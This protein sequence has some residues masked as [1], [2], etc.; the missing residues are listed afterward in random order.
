MYFE[1]SYAKRSEC[2][3]IFSFILIFQSFLAVLLVA[4]VYGWVYWNY[5]TDSKVVSLAVSADGNYTVAGT[6]NGSVYLFDRTG[7]LLWTHS[8]SKDVECVAISGDGS[9]IVVGVHE[10][11]SGK[12][13]VYLLDSLRNVIWQK[14]LVEGSWPCDVAVSPDAEYIATGDTKN[15]LY[16]YDVD[17]SLIWT[18]TAGGWVNAVSVSLEG[19]YIAAG[20]WDNSLYFFDETG[21]LLWSHEFEYHVDAVSVSPEGEYV[22]AGSPTVRDMFLYD[23]NGSLVLQTPFHLGVYSVSVSANGNRIAVG[24]YRSF[25]VIDKAADIICERETDAGV[26][27]V[28]ITTDGKFATFSCGDY[29]YF[30]EALPASEISCEVSSSEIDFGGSV[31]VSGYV[32]PPIAG[33]EVTLNYTRPDGFNLT[34]AV[35]SVQY[36]FYSDTYTPDMAGEWTVKASWMGDEQH[37]PSE[38]SSESFTVGRTEM[39]CDVFPELIFLGESVTV[40][41]SIKPAVSSA[42]VTLEYK[43]IM[44]DST[45]RE[46]GFVVMVGNVTT[47]ADGSF[48]DIATPIQEGMW[49]ITASWAGDNEHMGSETEVYFNVNPAPEISL[50]SDTPI[51]LYWHNERWYCKQRFPSSPPEYNRHLFMDMQMPVSNESSTVAF[52]PGRFIWLGHP[53]WGYWGVHT[54]R[55][56]ENTLTEEGSWKLSIWASARETNQHF[57]VRIGYWDENHS[58][59]YVAGR[60]SGYFNSSD[61]EIPKEFNFYFDL[62]AKIIPKGSCLGFVIKVG[63]DSNVKWFFDSTT[64]QSY[65]RIPSGMADETPPEISDPL[66]D[67]SEDVD[68]SQDVTVTVMVTDP[69]SG[70]NYVTLW[71]SVDD[72]STWIPLNMTEIDV[73]SY[74]ASIPRNE[75]CTWVRYKISACDNAGNHVVNDN[76]GYYF[77][78]HVIPEFPS[79]TNLLLCMITTLLAAAVYKRKEQTRA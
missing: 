26:G 37:A 53:E 11:L 38:S 72:G 17:G 13:D 73:N 54:G 69:V 71:Y 58:F 49:K 45:W 40:N 76:E 48:I 4:S 30:L 43:L 10:Y 68:P 25:T 46:E 34:R 59:N 65:L 6:E 51:T 22:A 23:K 63:P 70:V 66:Q 7:S 64:H 75:Y 3:A 60:N 35:T 19:K 31:T 67:P 74:Q 78:Y 55:I 8:F 52:Y 56:S 5:Q 15:V 16:L 39:T 61:P 21:D 12:S 77:A 28:A 42:Q 36:G 24:A 2:L 47:L 41:G 44:Q 14:D 79:E 32:S 20:S 50:L 29:V 1:R 33:A 57:I 27:D 62:P 9:R 18:F